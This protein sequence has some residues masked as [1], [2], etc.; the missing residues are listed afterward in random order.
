MNYNLFFR[1]IWAPVTALLFLKN[2]KVV[3]GRVMKIHI[4]K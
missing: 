4:K 3:K 2:R 1:A